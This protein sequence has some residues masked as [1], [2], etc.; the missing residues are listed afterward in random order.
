M[1]IVHEVVIP[2]D[3]P[4]HETIDADSTYTFQEEGSVRRV[5]WAGCRPVRRGSAWVFDLRASGL[6]VTEEA[7]G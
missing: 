6:L 1:H 4:L 5:T 7:V 3:H 2:E